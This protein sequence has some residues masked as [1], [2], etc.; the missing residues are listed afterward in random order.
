MSNLS[1]ALDSL[2]KIEEKE[3]QLA[4]SSYLSSLEELKSPTAAKRLI[5]NTK[6]Q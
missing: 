6:A 4:S 3:K 5:F 2:G 1:L